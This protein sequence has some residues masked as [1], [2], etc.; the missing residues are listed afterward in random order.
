MLLTF[1]RGHVLSIAPIGHYRASPRADELL[2]YVVETAEG[3]EMLSREQFAERFGWKN[4]ARWAT[5]LPLPPGEGR[6]EGGLKQL[7]ANN[8]GR[9]RI[10]SATPLHPNPLPKGEGT[11]LGGLTLVQRPA[12]LPGV[13][14][15]TIACRAMPAG[16]DDYQLID[17]TRDG[18]WLAHAG[19]D[20][21]VRLIEAAT[22]KIGRLFIGH[23]G[24]LRA[25]AFSPDGKLV[26]SHDP[27]RQNTC[28][29]EMATGSLVQSVYGAPGL[30]ETLHWSPDGGTLA[31]VGQYPLRLL[32]AASGEFLPQPV[33]LSSVTAPGCFAWSPDGRRF[34]ASAES[35]DIRVWNVA[36]LQPAVALQS[37][38]DDF[39][40]VA[41]AWSHDGM[42]L[43]GYA[44][45]REIR[46]WN[47]ATG[48]LLRTLKEDHGGWE[49]RLAWLRDGRRAVLSTSNPPGAQLWNLENGEPIR[50]LLAFEGA[51]TL[52]GFSLSTDER[53]LA[54]AASNRVGLFDLPSRALIREIMASEWAE[55]A[56]WS[57][58]GREL[59][60]TG[61]SMA[62]WS[63]GEHRGLTMLPTANWWGAHW[64]PGGDAILNT[65]G[66]GGQ[67]F[68]RRAQHWEKRHLPIGVG[69]YGGHDVASLSPNGNLLACSNND[70]KAEDLGK[71]RVE[72]WDLATAKRLVQMEPLG[73]Y[74]H[75]L[76]LSPDG[77]LLAAGTEDG[78][79]AIYETATGN[80]LAELPA[81]KGP[82][83][84]LAFSPDGKTLAAGYGAHDNGFVRLYD[85]GELKA[86]GR[87]EGTRRQ[88][89]GEEDGEPLNPSPLPEG[90]GVRADA[91]LDPKS[92]IENPKSAS[93]PEPKAD[94]T[95]SVP[96]TSPPLRELP[97]DQTIYHPEIVALRWSADGRTL[98]V[99]DH[100]A[101]YV[102]DTTTG[103]LLA[104]AP[105]LDRTPHGHRPA[106]FSPDGRYLAV[107]TTCTRVWDLADLNEA[108]ER[109]ASGV[110]RQASGTSVVRGPSSV[111]TDDGQLTT[112]NLKNPK[113]RLVASVVPLGHGQV[114]AASADGHWPGT[115]GPEKEIAGQET[116]TPRE[117]YKRFGW[118]NDPSK[119]VLP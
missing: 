53:V 32:D 91:S 96:A 90:E 64:L 69:N 23:G 116:L 47:P 4:N 118:K 81:S 99:L 35:G 19:Q 63:N 59:A 24:A 113:L 25:V 22:G 75:A 57:P 79:S 115:R 39:P 119:M 33:A 85:V 74:I 114:V 88:A 1:N 15:W 89:S 72:I 117:F 31:C 27:V 92:Q 65:V 105:R 20:G 86:S 109:K 87:P 7:A 30:L 94:G 62:V 60:V 97:C 83:R 48:Q 28:I 73:Q 18:K 44:G 12:T 46:V 78:K 9:E 29:W 70:I 3:Q 76:A 55:S 13:E 112:D 8:T 108:A 110:R 17:I 101:V 61:D 37:K 58:D 10:G 40:N 93:P 102:F 45:S 95:R 50:D 111:A 82:I 5:D 66:G 107:A 100:A 21:I 36:S 14:S 42:L 103:D 104:K 49:A 51:Y 54:L 52:Y 41:L 56:A 38:L 80:R 71:R 6:G 67:V 16:R 34:A 68:S 43:A 77:E 26:A 106:N 98:K 11:T 2:V 84:P